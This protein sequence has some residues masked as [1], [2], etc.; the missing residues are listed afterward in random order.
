MSDLAEQITRLWTG[1]DDLAAVM[2]PSEAR[3][4]VHE[5]IE[6][7]D[8]GEA[9][10]AEV[11]RPGTPSP[12]AGRAG[13]KPHAQSKYRWSDPARRTSRVT[14][15]GPPP[16]ILECRSLSGITSRPCFSRS[17]MRAV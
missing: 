1:R 17:L 10:V 2:S 3:T 16:N 5:V 14:Q 9:R 15:W 11:V 4:A 7:L 13:R 12:V 6:L 8:R